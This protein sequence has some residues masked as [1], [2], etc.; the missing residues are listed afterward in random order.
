MALGSNL[1]AAITPEAFVQWRLQPWGDARLT[2]LMTMGA[3]DLYESGVWDERSL[4]AVANYVVWQHALEEE[5]SRFMDSLLGLGLG[6]ARWAELQGEMEW[7]GDPTQRPTSPHPE[8]ELLSGRQN[9][10]A[11]PQLWRLEVHDEP[12]YSG[13]AYIGGIDPGVCPDGA[14]ALR[15]DGL[16][17]GVTGGLVSWAGYLSNELALEPGESYELS[18]TMRRANSRGGVYVEFVPER[19]FGPESSFRLSLPQGEWTIVTQH[20]SNKGPQSLKAQLKVRHLGYGPLWICEP[21]LV[22]TSCD[23]GAAASEVSPGDHKVDLSEPQPMCRD[24]GTP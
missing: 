21:Y 5:T 8:I 6:D 15:L 23:G 13:G 19:L 18:L 20:V 22:C 11:D 24:C 3:L 9:L 4:L 16:W 10:L 2:G 17:K 7:R 1:C 12:P 14:N